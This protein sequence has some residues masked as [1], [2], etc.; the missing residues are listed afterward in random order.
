MPGQPKPMRGSP[1][2][3]AREVRPG[4]AEGSSD[5]ACAI[6]AEVARCAA[7]AAEHAAVLESIGAQAFDAAGILFSD[8]PA[9]ELLRRAHEVRGLV[10]H[11][12][13]VLADLQSEAGRLQALAAIREATD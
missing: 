13:G 5:V 9:T 10:L 7:R 1:T 12:L 2:A 4:T 8:A 11:A 3:P 6:Q